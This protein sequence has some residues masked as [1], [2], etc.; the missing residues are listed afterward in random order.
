MLYLFRGSNKLVRNTSIVL[1]IS[2]LLSACCEKEGSWLNT[3]I[4]NHAAKIAA[5][6]ALESK[7]AE[8]SSTLSAN[9]AVI[10]GK[11]ADTINLQ[12]PVLSKTSSSDTQT[13]KAETIQKI[14]DQ[15]EDKVAKT[16]NL[17]T[18]NIVVEEEAKQSPAVSETYEQTEEQPSEIIETVTQSSDQNTN[19]E[20]LN[21]DNM[22]ESDIVIYKEK[23]DEVEIAKVEIEK[24]NIPAIAQGTT[25]NQML[26]PDEPSEENVVNDR[27][28]A[29]LLFDTQLDRN[30]AINVINKQDQQET[31]IKST[32][33]TISATNSIEE[34]ELTTAEIRQLNQPQEL[35]AIIET[36]EEQITAEEPVQEELAS[37]TKQIDDQAKKLSD[38]M[39]LLN[40]EDDTAIE[41]IV[42][43]AKLQVEQEQNL[44]SEVHRN[45]RLLELLS[46]DIKQA[47]PSNS[48][49]SQESLELL[50][51]ILSD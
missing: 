37:S 8:S 34:Q 44:E 9:A 38:L 11:K 45:Q 32:S 20:E 42:E 28:Q 40:E 27:Q 25:D 17:Q 49:I 12:E 29:K 22:D 48:K 14:T 30:E 24:T 21:T 5:A 13:T 46:K 51:E 18:N 36:S 50:N 31:T 23:V 19:H 4:K 10:S 43:Q 7:A 39:S 15:P 1:V 26:S 2:F 6:A 41:Q 47:N 33:P 16:S 3:V 35:S